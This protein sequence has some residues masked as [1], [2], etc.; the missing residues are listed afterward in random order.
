MTFEIQHI[1]WDS[2]I[3]NEWNPNEM[4][5]EMMR[6]ERAS[7]REFG[8][9]DPLTVMERDSSFVIIDG[10]QRF[11]AGKAE[12]ITTFPCI[13]LDV[14][15]DEAREL[16]IILNDTRGQFRDDRLSRLVQDLAERRERARLDHI[17]PYDRGR[18]DQLLGRREI[19]WSDLERRSA[20]T[21]KTGDEE[22]DPWVERVFRMPRSSAKVLDDA[23][24]RMEEEEGVDLPWR[25]LEM[26]AADFLAS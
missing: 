25:A 21:K 4:S 13:V 10:E 2:I 20:E 24:R 9:I 12:G 23:L 6:K 19:D 18:I 15:D 8:F 17:L 7:I 16:T 26:I 5:P 1:E 14:T 22:S 11:T 3:P